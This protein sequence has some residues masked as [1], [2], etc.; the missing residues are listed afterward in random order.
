MTLMT[1]KNLTFFSSGMQMLSTYSVWL[2]TA[3]KEEPASPRATEPS[4]QI[5]FQI[6]EPLLSQKLR[7]KDGCLLK[8]TGGERSEKDCRMD[9]CLQDSYG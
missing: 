3:T 4:S 5:T 7:E 1:E 8:E 9:L 2:C 6:H